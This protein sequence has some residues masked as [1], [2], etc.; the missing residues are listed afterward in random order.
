MDS[1][2]TSTNYFTKSQ[3]RNLSMTGNTIE[4]DHLYLSQ[5]DSKQPYV[6]HEK[7]HEK[8]RPCKRR[9]ISMF[10]VKE[11]CIEVHCVIHVRMK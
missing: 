5:C 11:M 3:L 4:S 2:Q 8:H 10:K 9:G 6:K 1:M 7:L